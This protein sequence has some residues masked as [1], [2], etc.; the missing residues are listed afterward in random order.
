[1]FVFSDPALLKAIIAA[2]RRGVNVRIMLNPSRRSGEAENAQSRK[3]LLAAGVDVI[4][5][6]P[7]FGMTNPW[8]WTMPRRSLNR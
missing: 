6:N 8:W 5:S 3:V 7:A 2:Q 1:M 4:D